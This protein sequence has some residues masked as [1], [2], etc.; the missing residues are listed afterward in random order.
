M[1]YWRPGLAIA[2]G[3]PD[4]V[5]ARNRCLHYLSN[6]DPSHLMRQLRK[7]IPQW[8]LRT[9][10]WTLQ[11]LQIRPT[12]MSPEDWDDL[13]HLGRDA[14][15]S[16]FDAVAMAARDTQRP[17]FHRQLLARIPGEDCQLR[18][19]MS[20]LFVCFDRQT[21]LARLQS[22]FGTSTLSECVDQSQE[23]LLIENGDRLDSDWQN[24]LLPVVEGFVL[25]GS[26]E[27]T[28]DHLDTRYA[29]EGEAIDLVRRACAGLQS[30]PVIGVLGAGLG[31]PAPKLS[32]NQETNSSGLC[33]S[34]GCGL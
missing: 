34:K 15:G 26:T 27:G 28:L 30:H 21:L 4:Y 3:M 6:E 25:T 29:L 17:S 7:W 2:S 33:G 18:R 23:I 9:A 20:N 16:V 14:H 5:S 12:R 10:F 32:T 8:D 22:V 31:R 24:E 13:T 1:D 19:F 11:A